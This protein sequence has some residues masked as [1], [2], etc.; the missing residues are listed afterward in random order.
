MAI[1]PG[2]YFD[3]GVIRFER[4]T[5]DGT[6]SATIRGQNKPKYKCIRYMDEFFE[7]LEDEP[8]MRIDIMRIGRW[9]RAEE[10]KYIMEYYGAYLTK[11]LQCVFPKAEI[12]MSWVYNEQ[13]RS[14]DNPFLCEVRIGNIDVTADIVPGGDYSWWELIESIEADARKTFQVGVK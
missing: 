9:Y 3:F 12:V 14:G 2:K 10:A 11:R 6:W 13:P 8:N 4:T 1:E 5:M 7:V